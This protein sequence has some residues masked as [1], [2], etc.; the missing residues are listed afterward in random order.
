LRSVTGSS[1]TILIESR[2]ELGKAF[3]SCT[4]TDTIITINNDSGFVTVLVKDSGFKRNNFILEPTILLG[5][6]SLDVRAGSESVLLGT[7]NVEFSSDVLGGKTILKGFSLLEYYCI[8][9]FMSP[10]KTNT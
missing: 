2:S 9:H 3:S 1:G 5:I 6:D 10:I 4:G 8:N 7:S